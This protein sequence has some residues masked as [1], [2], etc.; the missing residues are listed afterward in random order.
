MSVFDIFKKLEGDR[1][2][3]PTGAVEFIIAGLGNPGT[4][5]ENTRHNIGSFRHASYVEVETVELKSEGQFVKTVPLFS[6]KENFLTAGK[7]PAQFNEVVAVGDETLL[8]QQFTVYLSSGEWLLGGYIQMEATVVGVTDRGDGLYFHDDVGKVLTLDYLGAAYTYIPQYEPVPSDAEYINYRDAR[9]KAMY[10]ELCAPFHAI[11]EPAAGSTLREMLADE[12]YLSIGEY[13]NFLENAPAADYQQLYKMDY[14][15]EQGTW[16][17]A[18]LHGS[19]YE[20]VLAVSPA[21]FQK[22]LGSIG[23]GDQVSITISDYAY[24]DRV[25]KALEKDGYYAL[26]PY[27]LGATQID[28]ALAAQRQQSLFICLG[29]L[30]FILLL[31][32]IVLRAMFG[33]QT[34]SYRTLSD[35]GLTCRTAQ[36][37]VVLQVL[38][39]TAAG[40]LLGL[41]GIGICSAAGIS[42]I[43]DLTKYLFGIWWAVISLVHLLSTL[44]SAFAICA[45]LK[46]KVYPRTARARDLVIDEEVEA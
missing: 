9:S 8:G 17:V 31:Q 5:Y 19:T 30:L 4:E 12:V 14:I 1:A 46:K 28:P 6:G 37:S 34:D 45:A 25:I 23:N 38:L 33:M 26:S 16:H 29:A 21:V 2:P 10:G 24:T 22:I 13:G 35:M 39:F 11:C 15:T 32:L 40:Q 27:V 18:G 36:K 3:E 43:R 20:K 41:C 44:L 42:Q 7:L